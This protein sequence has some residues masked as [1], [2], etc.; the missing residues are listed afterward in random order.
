MNDKKKNPARA[1]HADARKKTKGPR[2]PSAAA[3][4]SGAAR[5]KAAPAANPAK[6]KWTLGSTRA[7]DRARLSE[8][9]AHATRVRLFAQSTA[10]DFLLVLLV[11]V[12]LSLTVSYGFNSAAGYR[13]NAALV[14]AMV[15]PILAALY[16]GTWSKRALAASAIATVVVCG[17]VIGAAAALSPESMF[18]DVGGVQDLDGNYCIFAIVVCVTTVLT[19]LLSRRTSLLLAL[20]VATVVACGTV[21]FLYRNWTVGEPGVLVT[22]A[23]LFG[24]GMLFVYQCYKQSIYSANRLKRTS[25]LGAFCFSALV[26]AACVLVGAAVFYG[27]VQA[28]DLS[29]PEIKFFEAYVSPPVDENASAYQK[30]DT[31]SDDTS[32]NTDDDESA[33]TGEG[34]GDRSEESQGM[35]PGLLSDSF[36]GDMARSITGYDPDNDDGSTDALQWQTLQLELIIFCALLA[37]LAVLVVSL[38]R[39]RRTWRLRRIAKRSNAYQAWY[40]YTFLLGRFRRLRLRKPDNLTPL[41]FAVGYERAMLPF[42]RHADGVDFVEVTSLYEDVAFGGYQPSDEELARLKKYYRAFFKNAREYTGW[43]KWALWRFW[44]I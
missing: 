35:G 8:K 38:M 27:V 44:R 4:T 25:F 18:S 12:A 26:G 15:V 41:E 40:L 42:T 10:F 31:Q 13:G 37:L 22:L 34:E 36:I 43:P 33:V 2:K 32:D 9:M 29:T 1:A 30:G 5:K 21:Q 19:F 39:Y 28:A 16:V 20:L 3:P 23:A 17:A 14:C 6:R 24:V 11:S 7:K